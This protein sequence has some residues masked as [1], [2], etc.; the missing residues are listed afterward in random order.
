VRKFELRKAERVLEQLNVLTIE[1]LAFL[2]LHGAHFLVRP[3]KA[4]LQHHVPALK[5]LTVWDACLVRMQELR[6]VRTDLG[7][8]EDH[9]P[10]YSYRWTAVG[11]KVMELIIKKFT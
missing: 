3:N 2:H 8:D 6:I 10:R 5:D 7:L 1:L 9:N 4:E 11:R